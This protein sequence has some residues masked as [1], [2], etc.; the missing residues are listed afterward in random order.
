[1][2]DVQLYFAV[3]IPTFAVLIGILMNVVHHNSVNARFNSMDARFNSLEL[4]FDTLIGKV[5]EIDNRVTRIEA[6]LDL[7]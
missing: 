4:R 2:N 7:R 6:K 3:G 5:V 1:M